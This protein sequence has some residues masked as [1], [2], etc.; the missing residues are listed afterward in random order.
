MKAKKGYLKGMVQDTSYSKN[1][2]DT[3]FELKN[4]RVVTDGGNS[5]GSLENEKGHVLGFTIPNIPQTTYTKGNLSFTIPAQ[6]NL[7]IVGWVVVNDIIIVATTNNISASPTNAVSQLWKFS[8]DESNNTIPGTVNNVLDPT[9][10]LIYNNILNFSTHYRVKMVGR[11]ENIDTLRVY[12]T[13]YNTSVKSFNVLDSDLIYT[14]PSFLDLTADCNL[15]QPVLWEVLTGNLPEGTCFQASY[16]LISSKN[17]TVSLYSPPTPVL[18]LPAS[19]FNVNSLENFSGEFTANTLSKAVNVRFQNL[20]VNYDVIEFIAIIYSALGVATVYKVGEAQI[21]LSGNIDYI[22]SNIQT[23]EIIPLEEYNILGSGFEIAKDIEIKDNFLLAANT[24]GAGNLLDYD[25]RTYRFNT[26]GKALIVDNSLNNDLEID[27]ITKDTIDLSTSTSIGDW[28][29]IPEDHDCINNYNDDS[30]DYTDWRTQQQYKYQANGTELGGEGPNIKYRFVKQSMIAS[31]KITNT[32]IDS[33]GLFL[34]NNP[35]HITLPQAPIGS[36]INNLGIEIDAVGTLQEYNLSGQF[37][38]NASFTFHCYYASHTRGEVY[39]Y[40]ICFYDKKGRTKFV[41]WIADIRIPEINEPDTNGYPIMDNTSNIFGNPGDTFE[42]PWLQNLGIEFE[43]NVSSIANEISG[44]SIVRVL[45]DA[46]NRTRLGTGMQMWMENRPASTLGA[47]IDYGTLDSGGTFVEDDLWSAFR[48]SA[49]GVDGN[50][51]RGTTSRLEIS[52]ASE[53]LTFITKDTVGFGSNANNTGNEAFKC[54]TYLISPIG[55]EI[56]IESKTGDYLRTTCYYNAKCHQFGESYNLSLGGQNEDKLGFIYRVNYSES[57]AGFGVANEFTHHPLELLEIRRATRF[58]AGSEIDLVTKNILATEYGITDRVLNCGVGVP[59]GIGI[60]FNTWT[61]FGIG[62][63]KGFILLKNNNY[64]KPWFKNLITSGV[65]LFN[66]EDDLEFS[67]PGGPVST[68]KLPRWRDSDHGAN[69]NGFVSRSSSPF[70]E[71]QYCRFINNQYGGNTYAIRSTNQY[72][73]IGHFQPH[74]SGNTGYTNA[75]FFGDTYLN[76]Y[77]QE[78]TIPY[79]VDSENVQNLFNPPDPN[80]NVLTTIVMAPVESPINLELGRVRKFAKQRRNDELS[81]KLYSFSRIDYASVYLSR[82]IVTNKFFAQ[83]FLL[84]LQE[85]HPNRVWISNSKTNGELLDSWRIFE[86][87]NFREVDGALGPINKLINWRGEVYFYQDRGLGRLLINERSLITDQS[88]QQLTLGTGSGLQDHS[89]IS[90]ETG[91]VHQYAVAGSLRGL[92][93]YDSRIK[94]MFRFTGEG[95]DPISD[96]KY[97]S[98]LFGNKIIGQITTIDKTLDELNPYPIGIEA[99]VD[100][101]YNRVLFTFLGNLNFPMWQP[102]TYYP[103]NTIINTGNGFI[104]TDSEYLSGE[105]VSIDIREELVLELNTKNPG[106][107]ISYNEFLDSYE[108]FYDFIPGI[109]LQYGRKLLSRSP[110]ENN[111]AFIH[112]IGPY[113]TFYNQPAY[114]SYLTTILGQHGEQ[115]KVFNNLE[116][117]SQVSQNNQDIPLETFS[118]IRLYNDYQNT[119]LLNLDS[120]NSRRRMRNWRYTMQRDVNNGSRARLRNPWTKLYLEYNNNNDKRIVV[121]DILYSFMLTSL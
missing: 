49:E 96:S 73:F 3:Y 6:N 113:C 46:D 17:S 78:I 52:G 40:G 61:P 22:Y 120:T 15:N 20:D 50:L 117:Y 100:Y 56:N 60:T 105:D 109:Y 84:Q 121:H 7:R 115:T 110:F 42:Y 64:L 74:F 38:N 23:A 27:A 53:A 37:F 21:P 118:K 65:N 101:R 2:E 55:R 32:A 92:Y 28:T 91:T 75:V 34:T 107:T 103:E 77:D 14:D 13:D 12:T 68:H 80:R 45:R 86:P 29:N 59:S 19:G 95:L 108:A 72:Y 48:K 69:A 94:K 104:I 111:K 51:N 87:L 99:V 33:P 11:Y 83:D 112:N 106:L 30:Q 119:G 102:N 58:L 66:N 43:V 26:L 85:E 93:H 71:V 70:K 44:F 25:A 31:T 47:V 54:L 81:T 89:Y 62:A 90:T 63:E 116:Y 57:P 35:P 88:G 82:D 39:R 98:S 41:K 8:F 36:T 18:P 114:K 79:T 76:Y 1:N 9:I 4:F 16:R 24:K 97:M 5:M 10:H 67:A